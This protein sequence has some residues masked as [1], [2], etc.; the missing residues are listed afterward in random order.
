MGPN[1][2]LSALCGLIVD[3]SF[4]PEDEDEDGNRGCPFHVVTLEMADGS[5]SISSSRCVMPE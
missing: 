2:E 4:P 1:F 5:A 3:E